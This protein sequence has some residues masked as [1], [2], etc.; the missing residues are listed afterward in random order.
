VNR[1]V[2]PFFF[3]YMVF[4][5]MIVSRTPWAMAFEDKVAP[6]MASMAWLHMTQRQDLFFDLVSSLVFFKDVLQSLQTVH[7]RLS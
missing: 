7:A 4:S 1:L 6:V 5:I 3:Y 2:R